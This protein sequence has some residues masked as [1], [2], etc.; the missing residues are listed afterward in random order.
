MRRG[1]RDFS[2]TSVGHGVDFSAGGGSNCSRGLNESG[3]PEAQLFIQEPDRWSAQPNREGTGPWCDIKP[4]LSHL[5]PCVCVSLSIRQHYSQREREN[6]QF[7]SN[8]SPSSTL[9]G[10]LTTEQNLYSVWTVNR[11]NFI[12]STCSSNT[13]SVEISGIL[14][15]SP[16]KVSI[17]MH[18]SST[19]Y[20]SKQCVHISSLMTLFNI[21]YSTV[22]VALQLYNALKFEHNWCCWWCSL[23]VI[24]V[25]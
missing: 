18:C 11:Y 24:I 16:N 19:F 12:N 1:L 20:S 22:P 10:G 4:S 17:I 7:F 13:Q 21:L 8:N 23:T 14:C 9:F 2:W 15:R 5:P 6:I 25:K 3:G